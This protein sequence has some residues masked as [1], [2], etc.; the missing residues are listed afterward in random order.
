[1]IEERLIDAEEEII[2]ERK[3]IDMEGR[4]ALVGAAAAAAAAAEPDA[5]EEDSNDTEGFDEEFDEE[6]KA[7]AEA[8][9]EGE[10]EDEEDEE[11]LFISESFKTVTF[12]SVPVLV[13]DRGNEREEDAEVAGVDCGEEESA[14]VRE[15]N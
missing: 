1:M 3:E 9:D 8:E 5:S 15:E 6:A 4:N 14:A 11:G 7:E 10:I 13:R 2:E 12:S